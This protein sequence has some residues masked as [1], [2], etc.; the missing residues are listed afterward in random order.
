MGEAPLHILQVAT[1]DQAGGAERIATNLL[2]EYRRRGHRVRLA[3]G[4]KRGDDPDVFELDHDARRSPW[5]RQWLKLEGRATAR[6]GKIR[7]AGRLQSLTRWIGQ[8]LR[9]FHIAQGREDF[10]YPAT[11]NLADAA[12]RNPNP[13]GPLL[14]HAHNLHAR[15]FDLRQLVP[16]S[17]SHPFFLTLHDMWPLTGHC[18][19]GLACER[20]ISGCGQCPDLN[21]YPPIPRDATAFNWQRKRAIYAQSRLYVATPSQW[22][23]DKVQRSI[24]APGIAE[25][26]VIPNGVDRSIFKPGPQAAARAAL[27]LPPDGAILLFAAAGIRSNPYKDYRTLRRAIARLAGQSPGPLTFLALGESAPEETIGSARIRFVPFEAEPARVA[28][29]YQAADLYLHAAR[30]DT[31]PNSIL[32]ALACARPVIATAV[33]GIPEQIV[34]GVTGLLTPPADADALAD[35]TARLLNDTPLRQSMVHQAAA[36]AAQ[37]FDLARQ[38]DQYLNWYRQTLPRCAV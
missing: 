38:A 29:Y 33:G 22:L 14:L 18:A 21:L 3:V 19:H 34:P 13:E 17:R 10:D 8:P 4:H 24:L 35:A 28:L 23:M 16:L 36:H 32:E 27:G 7:G 5:A 2:D 1:F 15:Y 31:F 37:R 12:A 30:A 20:W 9:Q 11:A 26:R 6:I 25:A